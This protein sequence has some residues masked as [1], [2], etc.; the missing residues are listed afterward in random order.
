MSTAPTVI[1]R[2]NPI[3]ASTSEARTMPADS[4]ATR[5]FVTAGVLAEATIG[6]VRSMGPQRLRN[7]PQPVELFEVSGRASGRSVIRC[8][9][10]S[11]LARPSR[12]RTPSTA[13]GT[14]SAPKNC[15]RALLQRPAAFRGRLSQ[16]RPS[17]RSRYSSVEISPRA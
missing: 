6:D 10:C 15:L 8:V 3:G 17:S 1:G 9:G 2:T 13:N 5:V 14:R 4:I 11:T 16:R 7:A 12:A